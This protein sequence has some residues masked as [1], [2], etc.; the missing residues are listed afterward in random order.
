MAISI[1]IPIKNRANLLKYSLSA[2]TK[3]DY[4]L[5]NLEVCILDG[6]SSDNLISIIERFSE[7]F[8]IKY[9]AVDKNKSVVPVLHNCPAST[10]NAGVRWVVS[11]DKVIKL[12]P[13]VI[14]LDKY[15]LSEVEDSLNNNPNHLVSAR[16][17]IITGSDWYSDY[18]SILENYSHYIAGNELPFSRADYHFCIGFS[19]TAFI[20]VGGLEEMFGLGSGCFDLHFNRAWKNHFG[21]NFVELDSQ[22][23]HLEH[24]VV[25]GDISSFELNRRIFD[26]LKELKSN[27]NCVVKEEGELKIVPCYREW[28][29]IEM[30]SK[31]YKIKEGKVISTEALS[32]S[33]LDVNLG[34]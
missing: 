13:E 33:S 34:L 4:N 15:L 31:V 16:A 6:G 20:T 25:G 10:I 26:N 27:Y 23:L 19:R 29:N 9:V 30:L 11:N 32:E 21:N 28:G 2:I 1:L 8:T 12:D 17:F 22:V 3:Q 5:E 18:D 24:P 7:Y 14:M